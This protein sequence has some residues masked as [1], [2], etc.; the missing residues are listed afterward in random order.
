MNIIVSDFTF[1]EFFLNMK[2]VGCVIFGI[3]IPIRAFLLN[4]QLPS[5][6]KYQMANSSSFSQVL[7]DVQEKLFVKFKKGS[8][9]NT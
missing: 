7:S 9:E 2:Y 8:Q 5:D 6:F 3:P 1:M 4:I